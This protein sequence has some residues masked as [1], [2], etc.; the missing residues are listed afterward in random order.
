M[1][2]I[3]PHESS[4]APRCDSGIQGRVAHPARWYALRTRSRF[5][6]KV[7]DA[8]RAEG[9][10]SFLPTFTE[11]VRWSDRF[12]SV[13]R[14]LFAGYLFARFDRFRDGSKVLTIT[15][16]I[17]ILGHTETDSIPDDVIAALRLV[18]EHPAPVVRCPYVAGTSQVRV[19]R[20][21]FAGCAGIVS[22]IKGQ[23]LLTIPVEILGRSVSVQI[24]SYDV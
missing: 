24:E 4:P 11:S 16:C 6:A 10:E 3:H 12:E 1:R 7:S 15:G 5:E 18:V 14:P 22:R 2:Q 17:Q 13:E 23:T 21:P 20:G 19:L 9:F 8:L